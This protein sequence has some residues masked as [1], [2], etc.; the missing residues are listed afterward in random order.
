[1]V[2]RFGLVYCLS[3]AVV[4][5]ICCAYSGAVTLRFSAIILL[6]NDHRGLLAFFYLFCSS[7]VKQLES[8]RSGWVPKS[9]VPE[10]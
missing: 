10:G 4:A 7:K 8:T 5:L 3:C 6:I 2:P 9:R 1:M